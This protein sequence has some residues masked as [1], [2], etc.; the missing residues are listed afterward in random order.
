MID[1]N[2]VKAILDP[3]DKRRKI[4]P[5]VWGFHLLLHWIASRQVVS[6]AEYKYHTGAAYSNKG[7]TRWLQA[8]ALTLDELTKSVSQIV[9]W[10][11]GMCLIWLLHFKWEFM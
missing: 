11:W 7:L 5:G 9:K 6:V 10:A 3:V 1:E 2:A 4:W 8:V